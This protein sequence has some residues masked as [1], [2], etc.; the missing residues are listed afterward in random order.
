MLRILACCFHL[1]SLS[2]HLVVERHYQHS[3]LKKF[4]IDVFADTISS[5][6]ESS[7]Y[8]EARFVMSAA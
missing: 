6:H 4:N 3:E 7:N 8:L 1:C 2:F 5:Q